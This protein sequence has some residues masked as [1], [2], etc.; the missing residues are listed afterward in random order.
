MKLKIILIILVL[1]MSIECVKITDFCHNQNKQECSG[2]YKLSCADILCASSL[3]VFK[4]LPV[5]KFHILIK[6]SSERL[7]I[8]FSGATFVK[9]TSA[10]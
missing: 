3:I 4:H 9:L 1:I 7:I 10:V 2:K 6:P 8:L 5:I